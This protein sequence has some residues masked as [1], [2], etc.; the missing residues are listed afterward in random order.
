MKLGLDPVM[1]H[2]PL[3]WPF[4]RSD[5]SLIAATM[6]G[7]TLILG[8]PLRAG[9]W[10]QWRGPDGTSVS[11]ETGLPVTWSEH[12]GVIWKAKIPEWGDSTPAIWGDAIF[13]TT[14]HDED[15]LLLKI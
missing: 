2:L 13:V 11:S 10:P 6:I 3:Q 8:G 1:R 5:R 14:Q 7:M 15:L 12:S 4:S 9:N